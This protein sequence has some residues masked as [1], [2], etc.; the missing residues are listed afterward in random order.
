MVD[1]DRCSRAA[2]GRRYGSRQSLRLSETRWEW[3]ERKKAGRKWRSPHRG[4]RA[5]MGRLVVRLE[6]LVRG[7]AELELEKHGRERRLKKT[8]L[9][10]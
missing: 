2:V 4:M 9:G 10:R 6:G 1:R 8:R 5:T 3:K 7:P